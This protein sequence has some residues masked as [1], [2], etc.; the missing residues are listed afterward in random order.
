MAL[1]LNGSANTIAGLAVG[2]LPD[3]CVDKDTIADE[4]SSGG[5]TIGGL[6]IMHGSFT[7]ADSTSSTSDSFGVSCQKYI[8]HTA[9]NVLSGFNSAPFV[10]CAIDVDHHDTNPVF[11]RLITTTG[12]TCAFACS[13]DSGLTSKTVRWLAVGDAS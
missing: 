6:R 8:I 7:L 11:V 9:S 4:Y 10:T 12:F 3:G 1:T 2:G 5:V 13:R